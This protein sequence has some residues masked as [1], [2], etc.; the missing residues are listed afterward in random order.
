MAV[1]LKYGSLIPIAIRVTL[2]GGAVYGS[3]KSG[4]WTDSSQSREKLDR[5]KQSMHKE[6]EYPK[7]IFRYT[8]NKVFYSDTVGALEY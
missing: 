6:L 2:S 3:V 1:L 5:L 7:T 8:K 4:I